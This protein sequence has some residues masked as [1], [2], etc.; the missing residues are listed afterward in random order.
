MKPVAIVL[1]ALVAFPASQAHIRGSR[2]EGVPQFRFWKDIVA[3]ADPAESFPTT[4][5][6]L[7]RYTSKFGDNPTAQDLYANVDMETPEE[8]AAIEFQEYITPA[9]IA[10][11]QFVDICLHGIV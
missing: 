1:L 2:P 10:T 6:G 11:V 8:A 4:Y 9:R 5:E 7:R 3:C